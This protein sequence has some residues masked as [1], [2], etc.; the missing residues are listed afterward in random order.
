MIDLSI[1]G[2]GL[3]LCGVFEKTGSDNFLLSLVTIVRDSVFCDTHFTTV[4]FG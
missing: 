2:V 1:G 4:H 3:E